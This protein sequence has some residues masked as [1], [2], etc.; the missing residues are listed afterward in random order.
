VCSQS[1]HRC[2]SL[3]PSTHIELWLAVLAGIVLLVLVAL[4]APT[5]LGAVAGLWDTTRPR[6]PDPE[7]LRRLRE[8]TIHDVRAHREDFERRAAALRASSSGKQRRLASAYAASGSVWQHLE[9]AMRDAG[10]FQVAD[11]PDEEIERWGRKLRLW[12]DGLHWDPLVPQEAPDP[13]TREVDLPP[14]TASR[15][16]LLLRRRP[17]PRGR[18]R[19]P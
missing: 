18:R 8:L 7:L 13:L 5:V 11:L 19:A 16:R 10:A 14:P 6:V 9:Q 4:S 2:P 12:R 17:G 15:G 3:L 1:P